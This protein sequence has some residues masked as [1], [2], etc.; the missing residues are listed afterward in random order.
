MREEGEM[1]S[2]KSNRGDTRLLRA[3]TTTGRKGEPMSGDEQGESRSALSW[4]AYQSAAVANE[5]W[6][7]KARGA[8]EASEDAERQRQ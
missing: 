1:H 5:E 7:E 2:P 3:G 6:G 4:R 8:R